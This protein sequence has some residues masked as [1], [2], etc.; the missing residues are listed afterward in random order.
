MV[1]ALGGADALRALPEEVAVALSYNGSTQAVM[2][3]TPADLDDFATGFTLTEG[4]ADPAAITGIT[5]VTTPHG[6]DL[7]IWLDTDAADALG[8][9]RRSMAGPVGCGLCGIES[10][11]QATRPARAVPHS[12]LTLSA[13]DV[14][15]AAAALTAHQPLHDATRAAHAAGF[16]VPGRGVG[17][18]RGMLA[19]REDVGRHNALDKLAGALMRQGIDPATGA[20]VITSRVSLDM[21]QK[22]AAIGAPV[23]I[24]ASAPTGAALALAG[25]AGLTVAGLVRAD[26]F[27]V[28]THAAR[29]TATDVADVA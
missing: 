26:R 23:L 7:Q 28:F 24:A 21:V 8:R 12:D 22:C 2:M 11:E 10:L 29:I 5:P 6:I 4:I 27:E 15:A 25:A 20:V 9:R 1:T 19:A 3:A 13:G 17:T 18:D 16:W 14:L